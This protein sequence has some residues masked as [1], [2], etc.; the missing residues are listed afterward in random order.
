MSSDAEVKR[1]T[2]KWLEGFVIRLGLCPFAALPFINNQVRIVVSPHS[3]EDLI[4]QHILEEVRRLL[5]STANELETTLIV[6]PQYEVDF[7]TYLDFAYFLEDVLYQEG[8][9]GI[10]QIATFHPKYIFADSTSDDPADYTN[11]SPFPMFHLLREDS[12][13]KAVENHPDIES[14]PERN[15]I[16]LRDMGLDAVHHLLEALK[17]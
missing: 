10:I 1:L 4:Q 6:C 8:Y 12:V 16:L 5:A 11:R 13:S 2:A 9:E 17:K 14:V 15:K 3:S 7:L